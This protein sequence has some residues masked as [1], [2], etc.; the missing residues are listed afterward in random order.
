ICRHLYE[1]VLLSIVG[2]FRRCDQQSEQQGGH[3]PDERHPEIHHVLGVSVEMM[4]G[5]QVS[6]QHAQQRASKNARENDTASC[7][8]AHYLSLQGL[9][10][11][12]ATARTQP[13]CRSNDEPLRRSGIL[14]SAL[15]K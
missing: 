4:F 9:E 8:R 11:H 5:Q 15:V 7:Y 12:T 13:L 10:M 2:A 1:F 14:A 6:E 3:R